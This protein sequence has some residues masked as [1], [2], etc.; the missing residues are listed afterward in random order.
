MKHHQCYNWLKSSNINTSCFFPSLSVSLFL[1]LS[2]TLSFCPYYCVYYTQHTLVCN[3][4]LI[5]NIGHKNIQ[6][7][8]SSVW[9]DKVKVITCRYQVKTDL[10]NKCQFFPFWE[11]YS[12]SEVSIFHAMTKQ[13]EQPL[14]RIC[15]SIVTQSSSFVVKPDKQTTS[16]ISSCRLECQLPQIKSN[17]HPTW[18][19]ELFF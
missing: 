13:L 10:K 15:T 8:S 4:C 5:L 9:W 7:K 18:I 1:Y 19:D 16:T 14:P 3:Y 6:G 12:K 2:L 17:S 11:S